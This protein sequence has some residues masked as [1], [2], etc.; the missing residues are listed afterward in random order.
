MRVDINGARKRLHRMKC[1]EA[2]RIGHLPD[3]RYTFLSMWLPFHYM[4]FSHTIEGQ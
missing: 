1:P 4:I 3:I 2:E